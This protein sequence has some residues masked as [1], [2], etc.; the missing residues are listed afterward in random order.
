MILKGSPRQE[1]P[2]GVFTLSL[3]HKG[4]FFQVSGLGLSQPFGLQPSMDKPTL[5]GISG[6]TIESFAASQFK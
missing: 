2:Y 5:Q 3:A 4:V 1:R 6:K